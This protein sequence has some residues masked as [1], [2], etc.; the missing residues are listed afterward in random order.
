MGTGILANPVEPFAQGVTLRQQGFPA[1]GV[2]RHAIQRFLQGQAR[3]AQLLLFQRALL[4]QFRHFF[5]ETAATQY[6]L[7]DLGLLRGQLRLQLAVPAA[8]LLDLAPHLLA[9][10]FQLALLVAGRNQ[11][12]LALGDAGFRTSR[13]SCN[14]SSSWARAS[15]PPWAS[16]LRRTRR[17]CR[18]TQ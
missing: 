6:Q 7:L 11:T 9:R 16:S 17:K 12:L 1:L 14:A 4:G 5:V 2:Q 13:R 3:L 10:A 8:L 15:M 18:P